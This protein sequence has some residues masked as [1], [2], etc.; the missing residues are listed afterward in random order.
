MDLLIRRSEKLS[1]QQVQ[2][3]ISLGQ[4]TRKGKREKM[5]AYMLP[6]LTSLKIISSSLSLQFKFLFIQI[7]SKYFFMNPVQT[8]KVCTV[9]YPPK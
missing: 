2:S 5:K 4:S 6:D 1:G 3:Q 9:I 7:I 8:Y